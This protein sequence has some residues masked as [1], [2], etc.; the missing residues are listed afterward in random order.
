[1]NIIS[2]D[3][4]IDLGVKHEHVLDT[5]VEAGC[6][7]LNKL[8]PRFSKIDIEIL[9]M[10]E[11]DDAALGYTNHEYD[12]VFVIE[13]KKQRLSEMIVTLAHEFVHVKQI[14]RKEDTS[15]DE[16]YAKEQGLA[17]E[18]FVKKKGTKHNA[19]KL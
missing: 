1:M 16:A 6:L 2:A 9:V 15:E 4:E 19:S 13:L 7:F 5:L 17:D 18:F 12:R 8:L 11:L 3:S 14:I 10:Q